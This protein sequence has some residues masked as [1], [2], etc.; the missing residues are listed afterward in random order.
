[1]GFGNVYSHKGHATVQTG[2]LNHTTY[3]V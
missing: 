2:K 3:Q 1:M